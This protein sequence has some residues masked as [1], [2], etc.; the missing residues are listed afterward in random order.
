VTVV[1]GTVSAAKLLDAIRGGIDAGS[2][3]AWQYDARGCFTPRAR[4]WS[5]RAWLCPSIIGTGQLK[6]ELVDAASAAPTAAL[7]GAYQGQFIEMLL[8]HCADQMSWASVIP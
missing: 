7:I 5:K 1:I 6:L 3:D 4:K 2:I 8:V